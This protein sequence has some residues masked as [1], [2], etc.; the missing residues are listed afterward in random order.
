MNQESS[1]RYIINH[2]QSTE[3]DILTIPLEDIQCIEPIGGGAQGKTY[4]ALYENK[5]V[6]AK[7]FS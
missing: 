7:I 5:F 2:D 3:E 1:G 4:R 6:C